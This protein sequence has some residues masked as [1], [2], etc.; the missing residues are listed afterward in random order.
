M[1][2]SHPSFVGQPIFSSPTIY[3]KVRDYQIGYLNPSPIDRYL[4]PCRPELA[5]GHLLEVGTA[6]DARHG[7]FALVHIKII[8]FLFFY[9]K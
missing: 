4:T 7:G 1:G 3:S 5:S 9:Y 8:K 6:V 2:I